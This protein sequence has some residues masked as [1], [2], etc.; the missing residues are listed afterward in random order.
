MGTLTARGR[1][2]IK[3]KN[4]AGP[5]RTYPDEDP[6]HARA[7]LSRVS[8]NGSPAVKAEVRANVHKKYPSMGKPK[9]AKADKHSQPKFPKVAK[10]YT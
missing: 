6:G 8:A 2:Q 10:E 4:F 1:K 5:G 9:V 7:A 3:A